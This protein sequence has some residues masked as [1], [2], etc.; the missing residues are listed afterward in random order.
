[1]RL[2]AWV[3][4]QIIFPEQ[5][6]KLKHSS[7]INADMLLRYTSISKAKKSSLVSRNQL[8][9]KIFYH[10][11]PHTVRCIWEHIFFVS[12]KHKNKQKVK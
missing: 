3:T 8:G 2:F 5:F 12:R 6:H 7:R 11:P 10:L 9:E 1:M 4:K